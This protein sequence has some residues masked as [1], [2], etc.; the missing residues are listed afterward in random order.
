MAK[1]EADFTLTFRGLSDAA[2]DPA[3]DEAVRRLFADPA[4]Y[5]GWAAAW[6]R[7]L[8]HEPQD[9]AT[10]R[11]AMRAVNAAFIPRNHRVEAV[12]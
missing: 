8:A 3:H 9:G 11:A 6:R 12:I 4:A 5:D 7:R 2:G 1:N 10:R